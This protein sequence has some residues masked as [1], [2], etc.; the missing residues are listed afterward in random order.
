MSSGLTRDMTVS[1]N[2]VDRSSFV[3]GDAD[4]LAVEAFDHG[5]HVGRD[6]IILD[7]VLRGRRGLHL[8]L[9]LLN[10]E[11]MSH[12]SGSDEKTRCRSRFEQPT[13]P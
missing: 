13:P 10:L 4:A 2:V 8:E 6:G 1:T 9:S 12:G 5:F 3:E 7:G 11:K